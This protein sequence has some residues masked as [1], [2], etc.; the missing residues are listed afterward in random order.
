MKDDIMLRIISTQENYGDDGRTELITPGR[1]YVRNGRSYLCYEADDD[2]GSPIRNI[3]RIADGKADV[4]RY[5]KDDLHMEFRAGEESM[6]SYPTP[7]GNIAMDIFTDEV[8]C[9][10]QEDSLETTIRYSLSMNDV[11]ISNCT[12]VIR[13]TSREVP[14]PFLR[15]EREDS[16]EGKW[17]DTSV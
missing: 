17:N 15:Q 4:L 12:V 6:T 2:D 7:A 1:Y 9:D 13:A 8:S 11:F 5:G 10:M 16:N 3:I 14:R